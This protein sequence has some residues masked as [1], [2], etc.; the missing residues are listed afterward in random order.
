[1][2]FTPGVVSSGCRALRMGGELPVS[3]TSSTLSAALS[4]KSAAVSAALSS[5]MLKLAA[6][7]AANAELKPRS[8]TRRA[9]RKQG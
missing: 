3:P 8:S 5:A 6:L 2:A 4:L 1:M 7:D 9:L